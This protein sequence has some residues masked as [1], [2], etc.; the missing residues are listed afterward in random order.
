MKINRHELSLNAGEKLRKLRKEFHLT[1]PEMADRLRLKSNNY[2]KNENGVAFPNPKTLYLLTTEFN[3]SLDW[4]FFDRGPK[5]L[6]EKNRE[7][8][9]EKK[10]AELEKELELARQ[11]NTRLEKEAEAKSQLEQEVKEMLDYMEQVPVFY[12][13]TLAHFHRFKMQ[14]RQAAEPINLQAAVND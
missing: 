13:E 2:R 6:S 5:F 7:Q 8:E 1:S 3:V 11:G 10:I 12:H 4:F 14:N 9:L